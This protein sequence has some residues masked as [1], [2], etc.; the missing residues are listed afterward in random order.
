LD[1]SKWLPRFITKE[2]I[3]GICADFRKRHCSRYDFPL[4]V[5]LLIEKELNLEIIPIRSIRSLIGI[6]AF[7]K[8]DFSGIIV[9]DEEYLDDRYQNRLRFSLAHEI[10]HFMLHRDSYAQ[11]NI[12]TSNDYMKLMQNITE[13]AYNAIE[14]QANQFAGI[15]LVPR[16]ELLMALKELKEII[17]K[18]NLTSKI[19]EDPDQMLVVVSPYISKRFGVSDKVVERRTRD[20]NLWPV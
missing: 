8:S 10:G 6:D 14:W 4:N 1:I 9:D 12:K 17:I 7:L 18:E 3:K 2:Q 13:K 20:E 19:K 5:E 16:E 11:F 15:L